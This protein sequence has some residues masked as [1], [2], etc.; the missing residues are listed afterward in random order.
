MLFSYLLLGLLIAVV[1]TVFGAGREAWT[2]GMGSMLAIYFMEVAVRGFASLFKHRR[3]TF[4][5]LDLGA[6]VFVVVLY[7]IATSYQRGSGFLAFVVGLMVYFAIVFWASRKLP[8]A[9]PRDWG[10]WLPGLPLL[11][12]RHLK[13]DQQDSS[14]V[15]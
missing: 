6:F 5:L 14:V 1:G 2:F 12:K 13:R 7:G 11:W 15:G 4:Q 8:V 10:N 9:P 3:I